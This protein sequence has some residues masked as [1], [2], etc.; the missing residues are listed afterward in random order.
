ME[1]KGLKAEIIFHVEMVMI[2]ST[3]G[4]NI[5]ANHKFRL[6]F[7]VITELAD[8]DEVIAR[9]KDKVIDSMTTFKA[10]GADGHFGAS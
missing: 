2:S 4:E 3:T 5:Y 9:M 6:A 7:M 10:G 1:N 8:L